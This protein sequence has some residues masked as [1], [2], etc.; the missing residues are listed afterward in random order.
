MDGT[1]E[2]LRRELAVWRALDGEAPFPYDSTVDHLRAVGKHFLGEELLELLAAC[3]S[4][5][6]ERN[7]AVFPDAF[8]GRFLDVLLDKFDD[9]YDYP[10]YTALPLLLHG[11]G[12]ASSGA[13]DGAVGEAANVT[14]AVTGDAAEGGQGLC[15]R[16]DR[17][18]LLLLADLIGFESLVLDGT[19]ADPRGM[20]PPPL[21]LSKRLRLA[22][23]VMEPA[24]LRVLEGSV[25]PVALAVTPGRTPARELADAVLATAGERERLLL[26][27]SVQPVH[28]LHDEYLFL[29]VL[30]CFEATFTFMSATLRTAVSVLR[31][32]CPGD[33]AALIAEVA[34]VL[35]ESLPLFS[36]LATMQ[37][38]SFQSFRQFTDGA[39]AI[40]SEGY[41]R[42]ESYC[43]TPARAR[44]DSAA[45]TSVPR[46]RGAVLAGRETVQGTWEDVISSG[47]LAEP[48]AAAVRAAARQLEAVHQRW[49]QTHYRLAVRMIGTR[50]GTGS[51]EGVPYLES[52]ISGRLF[53]AMEQ[54]PAGG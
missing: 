25:D 41:K 14:D 5:N 32:E 38:A 54:Q 23:R 13:A 44:L 1:D 39:S 10:S 47:W 40:Q 51:T 30:Q 12:E 16:R 48:D 52:V 49:K 24:A 8:L 37:P 43:S 18:V 9:R 17:M 22:V 19:P 3:R 15:D 7:S 21:L 27:A 26:R 11:W 45:F 29:R 50:T 53:P 28:V 42:F 34:D 2:P 35:R 6:R 36:L 20:L 31:G 4:L 46:V 33:A